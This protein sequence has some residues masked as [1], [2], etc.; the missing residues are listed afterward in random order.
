[1]QSKKTF[2]NNIFFFNSQTD[3]SIIFFSASA[4]LFTKLIFSYNVYCTN[5][6]TYWVYF[7]DIIQNFGTFKIYS[8]VNIYNHPP[9]ISW[10]LKLIKLAEVKSPFGFPFLFRLLPIFAD[11]ASV[12]VIWKLLRSE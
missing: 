7:S 11:Y 3:F 2:R 8:L 10:I 5:D 9:L 12:F 6:I 4:I 1:M